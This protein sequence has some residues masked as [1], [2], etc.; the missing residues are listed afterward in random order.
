MIWHMI[1]QLLQKGITWMAKRYVWR[2]V[3]KIS[4]ISVCVR[5]CITRV[6]VMFD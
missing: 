1:E 2:K 3:R 5:A 4:A 6:G